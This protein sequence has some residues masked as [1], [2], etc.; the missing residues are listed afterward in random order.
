MAAEVA[1]SGLCGAEAPCVLAAT[2]RK[3]AGARGSIG[4][5]I[6]KLTPRGPTTRGRLP[7]D[8]E[9]CDSVA[10]V[11]WGRMESGEPQQ[12]AWCRRIRGPDGRYSGESERL[13]RY[14]SHGICSACHARLRAEL[15]RD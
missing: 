7:L 11:V 10:M 5:R 1:G 13:L 2:P 3:A 15:D 6:P 12:C 9:G 14:V 8:E 4:R